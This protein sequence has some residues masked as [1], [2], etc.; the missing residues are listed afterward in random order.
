MTDE[1]TEQTTGSDNGQ[2][3]NESTATEQ[4]KTEPKTF[5]EDDLNRIVKDRLD[6]ERKKFADYNDLKAAKAKLDELEK[7]KLSDEEKAQAKLKELE[8]KIAEKEAALA[9]K[10]LR[11]IKRSKIEQ[12][13]ADGKMKLPKGKT[14][15]SLVK[16]MVGTTEEEIDL[17]LIE[18]LGF[19]PP[20]EPSKAIGG[21]SQQQPAKT[22][23]VDD[24]IASL[25][26]QASTETDNLKREHLQMEILALK[27]QAGTGGFIKI[28]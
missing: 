22:P 8:A 16:R 7:A 2:V 5:T 24:R 10:A 13:I 3:G 20:D 12:A 27:R 26:K 9:E 23:D 15:E 18:L 19:F 4:A 28:A 6:R 1:T 11:D 17:D 14:I 21:G 25:V